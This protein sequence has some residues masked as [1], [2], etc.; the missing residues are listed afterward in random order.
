[1]RRREF[2]SIVAGAAASSVFCS[3]AAP[4]GAQTTSSAI[5]KLGVVTLGV[6]QSSLL[7]TAF[8]TGLRELG[9]EPG[10]NILL[11]FRNAEG[12]ADRLPALVTEVMAKNIDIIVVESIAA[13]IVAK[14]ASQTIPIVVAI[15]SDPVGAG[16][17]ASLVRPGGN[18]TGLSL[19]SEEI[20]PRRIQLIREVVPGTKTIAV[21]YNPQ[22][23]T[24]ADNIKETEAAARMFGIQVQLVG[25]RN[26]NNL[27]MAVDNVVRANPDVFMTL[28]DGMLLS[29]AKPIGEFSLDR[30]LP[31]IF[32]ERDFVE[33]G[34][35]MAYG[36]SLAAHF[37]RAAT[38]VDKILKG[39][40]P[41]D[42]PAEQPT[43]FE[44]VVNLK[45]AKALGLTLSAN[46][47]SIADELIQ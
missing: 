25:V 14:N 5:R 28:P 33:S 12:Q 45:S 27:R 20:I 46:V 37:H 43:R 19:Q 13:A 36:P 35:L 26:P 39:A 42:L 10:R 4:V 7:I 38:Y 23:P 8:I 47:I 2:I 34:G 41:G 1:M 6:P 44:L 16:V 22:R 11:E 3:V 40:K 21:L 15:A 31:G 32:P 29:L 18:A 30:R 24:V 17:F 9:Y